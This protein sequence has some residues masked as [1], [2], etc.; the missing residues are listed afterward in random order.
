MRGRRHAAW[1]WVL[2][3]A[4]IGCADDS[5][6]TPPGRD[7][8]AE[9]TEGMKASI[10]ADLAGWRAG[11]AN[12]CDAAPT[13]AWNPT[14]HSSDVAAMR[15]AWRDARASYEHIEGAIAPLYP[16]IDFATDAR[17]DDYL[18]ELGA[19]GDPDPFDDTGVTGMHGVE[20]ILYAN[21]VP[22]AVIEFESALPGYAEPRFPETDAEALAF[23]EELCAKLVDDIETLQ[24]SW[25]DPGTKLDLSLAFQGLVDLMNEQS[26]KVRLAATGEEES[27]YAQL[28][29]ADLRTNLDGAQVAYELFSEWIKSRD[30]G[31]EI[32]E[33][34]RAGFDALQ[35]AYSAVDGDAIPQPPATWN[36]QDPSEE[37]LE[38]PFGEL[39]TAVQTAVDPARDGSIVFEMVEA[40]SLVGLNVQ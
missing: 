13:K 1:I 17:Y 20:R 7:Y 27:R 15:A 25:D 3:L 6:T 8:E 28:T 24:T 21:N 10:S 22:P 18:A 36:P 31:A 23:K 16:D 34:I 39:Y 5:D 37:D 38:T 30:G 29:M 33:K 14:T 32:D 11:A 12:L 26:E 2:G 35:V 9:V 40:G 4:M 19:D